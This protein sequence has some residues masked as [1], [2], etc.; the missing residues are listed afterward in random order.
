MHISIFFSILIIHE[1]DF[2]YALRKWL[3][4]PIA[5]PTT[6]TEEQYNKLQMATRSIIERCNGVGTENEI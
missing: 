5:N 3:L 4:T 1:G 2:G 6:D